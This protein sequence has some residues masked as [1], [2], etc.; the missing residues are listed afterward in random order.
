[1]KT[2][3]SSRKTG[4]S[5]RAWARHAGR[6]GYSQL[7]LLSPIFHRLMELPSI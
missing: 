3:A 7:E 6:G 5:M 1:M 4:W 2:R